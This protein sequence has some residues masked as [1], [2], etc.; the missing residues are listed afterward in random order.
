MIHWW[1][2]YEI[3][4]TKGLF[5]KDRNTV[6]KIIEIDSTI[7][8]IVIPAQVTKIENGLKKD[9]ITSRKGKRGNDEN[10]EKI[11]YVYIVT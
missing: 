5:T 6:V 1:R 10:L 11:T 4:F 3:R 8:P 7:K 9:S 2:F